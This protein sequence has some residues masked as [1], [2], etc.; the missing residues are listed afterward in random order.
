M[1]FGLRNDEIRKVLIGSEGDS[2]GDSEGAD[3][4]ERLI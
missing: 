2:G 1:P 3:S 4:E